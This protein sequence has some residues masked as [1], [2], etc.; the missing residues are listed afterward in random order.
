[1][2]PALFSI[3]DNDTA[4]AVCLDVWSPVHLASGYLLGDQQGDDSLVSALGVLT[5]F[6]FAEPHFFPGFNES[7]LNQTC[8]V[9]VG[10]VGWVA[11]RTLGD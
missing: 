3:N 7:D 11:Q 10:A 2:P 6:E 8:D 4:D 1:M 9:V 5:A